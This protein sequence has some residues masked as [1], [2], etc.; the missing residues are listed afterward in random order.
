[1]LSCGVRFGL[2]RFKVF[3]LF[4][5]VCIVCCWFAC[6]VLFCF[7]RSV[8]VGCCYVFCFCRCVMCCSGLFVFVFTRCSYYLMFS[9]VSRYIFLLHL[10]FRSV[11]CCFDGLF[12]IVFFIGLF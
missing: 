6:S 9:V 2:L 12:V 4:G 10:L 5:V 7:V 1:M 11:C 8:L 3:R